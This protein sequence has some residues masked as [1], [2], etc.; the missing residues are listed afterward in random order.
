[1]ASNAHKEPKAY[2]GLIND[3]NRITQLHYA[4]ITVLFITN[5]TMILLAA[6]MT[7][8]F[9]AG[10]AYFEYIRQ[11]Q[12]NAYIPPAHAA[13]RRKIGNDP[14]KDL[15]ANPWIRNA[16]IAERADGSNHIDITVEV[17]DYQQDKLK[18]GTEFGPSTLCA[19]EDQPIFPGTII[20][21]FTPTGTWQLMHNF[22]PPVAATYNDT[23]G[24]PSIDETE[25][26]GFYVGTQN[27][28]RVSTSQGYN[29]IRVDWDVAAQVGTVEGDLYCMNAAVKETQKDGLQSEPLSSI[30]AFTIDTQD[31]TVPGSLSVGCLNDTSVQ[32][33]TSARSTDRNLDRYIIYVKAG[34]SGV[35][36]N[37][38]PYTVSVWPDF[39]L[40]S[41]TI[42]NLQPNT[43]Y[44]ANVWV[45]DKFCTVNRASCAHHKSR[46]ATEVTFRTL[47]APLNP[48]LVTCPNDSY[49]SL[50]PAGIDPIFWTES[51]VSGTSDI[52]MCGG[53]AGGPT[54]TAMGY[55][56][57]ITNST[58]LYDN[59]V[60]SGGRL[61]YRTYNT[62]RRTHDISM[63]DPITGIPGAFANVNC[64]PI[65]NSPLT[66][67]TDITSAWIYLAWEGSTFGS[68]RILMCDALHD[69]LGMR[70][71]ACSDIFGFAYDLVPTTLG[72]YNPSGSGTNLVWAETID[73][74]PTRSI[75]MCFFPNTQAAGRFGNCF[76]DPDN[77]VNPAFLTVANL[78]LSITDTNT[79]FP[80][81]N[82]RYIAWFDDPVGVGDF[83][84]LYIC[85]ITKIGQPGGCGMND[86]KSIVQSGVAM[87]HLQIGESGLFWA[88]R[89]P[90][91]RFTFVTCQFGSDGLLGQCENGQPKSVVMQHMPSIGEPLF[92]GGFTG[93]N[94]LWHAVGPTG[95]TE[96]YRRHFNY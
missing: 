13:L 57:R 61:F 49:S 90:D 37:D 12:L 53:Q 46:A 96:I 70:I 38:N 31:P 35:T 11:S 34:T 4:T 67:D 79:I 56:T 14:P 47:S 36:E 75:R 50:N 92:Q 80:R 3:I 30:L 48:D 71:R 72:A 41:Y 28:R 23:V 27:G 24:A 64:R 18:L 19:P 82:S 40:A 52:I 87:Q 68:P 22:T 29:V 16:S 39:Y 26:D 91:F 63:C 81:S 17:N 54:C 78:S 93:Y 2:K 94:I 20:Q 58:G 76:G 42:T 32:L 45:Y 73:A 33:L 83:S 66:D 86:T 8:E 60:M 59:P 55:K 95:K 6:V 7:N 44:V 85:D 10:L 77:A 89:E 15:P 51:R 65:V 84:T 9:S 1:M 88:E 74:T 69:D 25:A 43:D 5:L 21:P 62:T